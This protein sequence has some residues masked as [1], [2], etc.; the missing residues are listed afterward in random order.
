MS[1]GAP[2]SGAVFARAGPSPIENVRGPDKTPT[3]ARAG[4]EPIPVRPPPAAPGAKF[5]AGILILYPSPANQHGSVTCGIPSI[6]PFHKATII[7]GLC[8]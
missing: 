3:G 2:R 7:L 5:G 8:A 6:A 4:S 1:V